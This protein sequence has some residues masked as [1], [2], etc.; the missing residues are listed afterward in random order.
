M[1]VEQISLTDFRNYTQSNV[2]LHPQL[3]TIVGDNAQGKTNCL[4]ALYY[5]GR[6][7]SFRTSHRADLVRE[8]CDVAYLR[9]RVVREDLRDDLGVEIGTIRRRFVRNEKGV[10]RP[11][12]HWPQ[13]ILFAPEEVLLFKGGPSTR[14]DY[15]DALIEGI[16]PSY[17]TVRKSYQRVV[18]QRNRCL[19]FAHEQSRSAVL[20]QLAPWNAQLVEWG[21]KM[22]AHRQ[23]WT[24]AINATLPTIHQSFAAADGFVALHYQPHV[25]DPAVFQHMLAERE[26]EELARGVTAVGPHRDELAVT[27][28]GRDLR[29]YGSQGQHRSVV[30]SLKIAEVE[31]GKE[32]R[33][34]A[35]IFLLDDVASELDPG[36]TRAFFE[37]LVGLRCQIVTTTTHIDGI[38]GDTAGSSSI[39]HVASGTIVQKAAKP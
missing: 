36:R 29:L 26:D 17:Y 31:L 18:Q 10:R 25:S 21:S 13:V 12:K 6:G 1:R 35:P 34:S 22:L 2:V 3:T 8:G 19:Q 38:I 11:D 7:R 33:G 32:H 28:G 14:R 30:L 37:R 24:E 27:M 4:E 39:L 23:R 15:L 16:D 5:L 20:D 9:A